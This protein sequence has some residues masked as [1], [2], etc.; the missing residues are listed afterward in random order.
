M[1]SLNDL[2]PTQRTLNHTFDGGGTIR[3]TY[4]PQKVT[5]NPEEVEARRDSDEARN[6][7]AEDIA[8][9]GIDWD[10]TGPFPADGSLVADGEMFP[11]DAKLLAQ[12]PFSFLAEVTMA[13]VMDGQPDPTKTQKRSQRL[14]SSRT[15]TKQNGMRDEET[16]SSL[17]T[18]L[19]T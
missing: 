11:F 15:S 19:P 17:A 16:T 14:G 5:F 1:P 7:N 2:V 4:N 8:S 3:I 13:L 12:L 18:S 10:F 6:T 9:A